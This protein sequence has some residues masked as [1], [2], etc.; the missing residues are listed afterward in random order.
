MTQMD[1]Q[2]T[3]FKSYL[4]HAFHVKAEEIFLPQCEEGQSHFE[5]YFHALWQEHIHDPTRNR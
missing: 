5:D 1:L 4:Q 2:S 3:N